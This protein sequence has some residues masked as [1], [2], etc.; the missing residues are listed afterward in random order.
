MKTN[1]LEYLE[2][3]AARLPNKIAF[4]DGTD[5]I[6]FIDL[7]TQSRAGGSMLCRLGCYNEPIMVIMD[8]HPNEI[9]AFLSVV[10]AGCFYV[11][12]DAE[13]PPKRIEIISDT[14]KARYIIC[15][16]KNFDLA[17]KIGGA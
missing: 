15:D 10:Y 7:Y 14:T 6:S 16:E 2:E 11:P 1:I 12:I 3:T 17:S 4:S 13:M 9:V 8:K 5:S